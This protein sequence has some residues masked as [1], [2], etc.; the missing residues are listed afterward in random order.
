MQDKLRE[1]GGFVDVEVIRDTARG[2]KV[3]QRRRV[4][5]L[6]VNTGKRQIWRMVMGLNTNIFDQGRIGINGAAAGSGDTNV[7]TAITGTLQTIDSLSLLA[8][9][10]TAQ[11]IWSYPSGGGSKS[12]SGIDECTILNQNTS[13]GGSAMMR[14]TF[15]AVNKTTGDKLRITYTC[16]IT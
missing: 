14:S 3:I 15:T 8:A 10:R 2:P 5:N 9:T 7:L 6:V 1:F 4:H 12:V 13:P 11:W 16:R